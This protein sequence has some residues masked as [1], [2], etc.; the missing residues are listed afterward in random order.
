[1][2]ER[3]INILADWRA[4]QVAAHQARTERGDYWLGLLGQTILMIMLLFIMIGVAPY[5]HEIIPDLQTGAAPVSPWNRLIWLSLLAL[6][7]PVFW[8]RRQVLATAFKRVWPLIILLLWFAASTQW[9]LDPVVSVRRIVLYLIQTVICL[10][11]SLSIRRGDRILVTLAMTCA[12]MVTIDFFSWGL[13]P[14]A[15]MTEF[16]LAAI[17]THK[18][19]LG[20][21]MM[22]CCIVCVAYFQGQ[23][24]PLSRVFWLIIVL[25][26]LALLVASKSKTS[27]GTLGG[28]AFAGVGLLWLLR[29]RMSLIWAIIAATFAFAAILFL[30]WIG[31]NAIGGTDPLAPLSTV[32]FTMRTDVWRFALGVWADHPWKGIGFGSFWDVDPAVQP[33]LQTDAWFSRPEAF[34]NEGHNG[35]IDILVTTGVVGLVG[36]LPLLG[37]WIWRGLVLLRLA[38]LSVRSEDREGVPY[39]VYLGIFPLLFLFHNLLESSYF[40][41]NSALGVLMLMV[42]MDIDLRWPDRHQPGGVN[43]LRLEPPSGRP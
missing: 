6:A 17:H 35:Y 16:G 30:A 25:A 26:A 36:A 22:Y 3:R 32:T 23:K 33:S 15:S 5:Q 29:Q 2:S 11:L 19:T 31:W 1:M 7:T 24:S 42:G 38:L 37:R 20:A 39:L 41:P 27:L 9:A 12:L 21:I 28:G 14:T 13:A 4:G 18:N 43:G 10:A 40:T 34:A 8:F